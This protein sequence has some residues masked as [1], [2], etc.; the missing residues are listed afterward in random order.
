MHPIRVKT[1]LRGWGHAAG[2]PDRL[3]A[4]RRALPPAGR[5]APGP[6]AGRELV[7]ESARGLQ[8]RCREWGA[9][10]LCAPPPPL[11]PAA[12]CWTASAPHLPRHH[13]GQGLSSARCRPDRGALRITLN[14]TAVRIEDSS[15]GGTHQHSE[16]TGAV[17]LAHEPPAQCPALHPPADALLSSLFCSLVSPIPSPPPAGMGALPPGTLPMACPREG[18]YKQ[19]QVRKHRLPAVSYHVQLPDNAGQQGCVSDQ[20]CRWR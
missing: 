14:R 16:L 4:S 20:R 15:G 6:G 11:V 3:P 17:A 13:Y 1:S 5:G 18:M 8:S 7:S 9:L 2:E 10:L 12:A 19:V